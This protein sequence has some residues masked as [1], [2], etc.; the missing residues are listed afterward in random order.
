[1]TTVDHPQSNGMLERFHRRLKTALHARSSSPSWAAQLPL[2]LLHL[3]ATPRD[4]FPR[5]PAEA[6]YGS[7]LVLPGQLL[8][9]PEPPPTFFN[10]LEQAM[11]GF[12]PAPVI[13]AAPAAEHPEEP[14]QQLMAAPRVFVRRDGHHGPLQ[15]TWDSPYRVIQRSRHVF[16]L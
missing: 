12:R 7:Q 13:H 10:Q 3:C 8:G 5:S 11:S 4:D 1:M 6:V 14:P 2:I 16:R 15:T 9:T